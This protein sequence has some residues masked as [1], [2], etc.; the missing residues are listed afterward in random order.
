MR[1]PY[2]IERHRLTIEPIYRGD[3]RD[4]L[5]SLRPERSWR[6]G[7]AFWSHFSPR[8]HDARLLFLRQHRSGVETSRPIRPLLARQSILAIGPR[9][10]GLS[11]IARCLTPNDFV[12]AHTRQVAL[13]L[14]CGYLKKASTIVRLEKAQK[15]NY[16]ETYAKSGQFSFHQFL[17]TGRAAQ[18]NGHEGELGDDG[19]CGQ[20]NRDVARVA[21]VLRGRGMHGQGAGQ[22]PTQNV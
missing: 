9:R 1:T 22:R 20:Q 10:T 19:D 8:T 14:S 16:T 6:S 3:A 7:R 17:R 11:R 12:P 18:N 2:D 21:K 4:S 5:V 15:S 13:D